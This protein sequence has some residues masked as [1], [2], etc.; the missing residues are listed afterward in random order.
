M[1]ESP[2]LKIT[3]AV[4]LT[5]IQ[6][7]HQ[8]PPLLRVI[9]LVTVVPRVIKAVAVIKLTIHS[10]LRIRK[11]HSSL[12]YNTRTPVE[13]SK[14]YLCVTHVGISYFFSH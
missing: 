5:L 3:V 11:M 12:N 8:I 10:S 6:I 13:E 9:S 7:I 4:S 2:L 1:R 14:L